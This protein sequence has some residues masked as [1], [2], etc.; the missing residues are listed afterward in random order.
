MAG[1]RL[2]AGSNFDNLGFEGKEKV[3]ETVMYALLMSAPI[4]LGILLVTPLVIRV[5]RDRPWAKGGDE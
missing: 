1:S 5:L 2:Y 3:M 4:I